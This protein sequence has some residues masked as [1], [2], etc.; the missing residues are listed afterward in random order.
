M[1]ALHRLKA[2]FGMVP[3]DE[4]DEYSHFAGGP[5]QGEDE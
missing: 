1:S 5:H 3:A 4:L 2:Y